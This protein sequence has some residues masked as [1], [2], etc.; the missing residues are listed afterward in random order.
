M[1]GVY[2]FCLARESLSSVL[3]KV[4]HGLMILRPGEGQ[5]ERRGKG[6]GGGPEKGRETATETETG[7]RGGKEKDR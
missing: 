4:L 1:K 3:K 6:G 2:P 5:R 7:R